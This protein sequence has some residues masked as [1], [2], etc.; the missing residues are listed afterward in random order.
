MLSPMFRLRQTLQSDV[1]SLLLRRIEVL[2]RM[3]VQLFA[4]QC[5]GCYIYSVSRTADGSG[6]IFS[7]PRKSQT[8]SSDTA[9]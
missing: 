3:R 7:K 6:E 9:V 5:L 4:P 8:C 2:A 1:P